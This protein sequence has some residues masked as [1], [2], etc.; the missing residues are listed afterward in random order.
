MGRLLPVYLRCAAHKKTLCFTCHSCLFLL[1]WLKNLCFTCHSCLFGL[2]FYQNHLF[3]LSFL[4]FK[5]FGQLPV[6]GILSGIS[7]EVSWRV[8]QRT[9]CWLKNLC[10][11]CHSCLFGWFFYQNPLFYLSF[12]FFLTVFLSK[13]FVLLV[14]LVFLDGFSIKT[15]CFT[16]HSYD[17]WVPWSL[18][19]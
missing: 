17:F 2:F 11:T 3:Y 19:V 18:P 6:R 13:P 1:F 10:C 16:C 5:G 7:Q 8:S 4:S 12:L 14:I 15:I 9:S